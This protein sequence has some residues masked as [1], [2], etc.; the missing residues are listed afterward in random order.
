VRCT[1]SPPLLMRMDSH[2]QKTPETVS[3]C[4]NGYQRY[5]RL[6]KNAIRFHSRREPKV[7]NDGGSPEHRLQLLHASGEHDPFDG[8]NGSLVGASAGPPEGM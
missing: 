5:T 6:Q 2:S 7:K 8:V 1:Q 4:A 3:C